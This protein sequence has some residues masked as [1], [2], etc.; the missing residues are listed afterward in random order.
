[1]GVPMPPVVVLVFCK[2]VIAGPADQNAGYTG[3]QNLQWDTEHSQMVCRRQEMIG[4][5]WD[6]THQSSKYR[7][8]RTACPVRIENTIT[9][10]TIGWK[11]PSCGEHGGT[12]HCEVDSKI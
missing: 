5:Q 4:A 7:F 10:E 1:M 11:I 2:V 8:W 9:G 3:H 12:V 6:A